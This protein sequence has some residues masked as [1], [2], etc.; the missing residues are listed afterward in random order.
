MRPWSDSKPEIDHGHSDIH[1]I[2]FDPN[3][4][5]QLFIGS[6]GGI[7]STTDKGLTFRSTYNKNLYNLQFYST[8]AIREFYDTLAASSWSP[9]IIAGGTQDNGNVYCAVE[10]QGIRT[11]WKRLDYGD[12][13]QVVC[14][15]IDNLVLHSQDSQ[16][17]DTTERYATLG[18]PEYELV[19]KNKCWCVLVKRTP[20]A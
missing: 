19:E 8:F 15:S 9:N 10:E 4:A 18:T 20:A 16:L 17:N 11:P 13:G 3:W 2:Y 14:T 12:G 1:F 6:D 5:D 7:I